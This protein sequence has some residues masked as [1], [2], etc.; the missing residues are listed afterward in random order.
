MLDIVAILPDDRG[1]RRGPKTHGRFELR[2]ER[3]HVL[4]VLEVMIGDELFHSVNWSMRGILLDGICE[5]IGA[6]V[7]GS[8]GLPGSKEALPFTATVIRADL[9]TGNCAICFEDVRT[10]RLDFTA[11]AII[12]QLQRQL[13]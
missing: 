5:V 6:R 13:H 9:N 8:M 3:R 2:R 12:E 7:R 4:P 10:E 11:P 1:M